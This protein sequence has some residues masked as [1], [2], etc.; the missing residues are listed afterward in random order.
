M[1]RDIKHQF[2]FSHSPEVVW[3]YLTD[4]ELLALWLMPSDF[5]LELD[6][7]FQFKTKPKIN[8]GF[9]GT[10]YCKVLEI[11]P[12]RKL[13]YSWQGGMS[14]EI[15]K[16]D[17]IVIWTLSPTEGGTALQLEHNGFKGFKNYL[18]YLIM[19]KGWLKIGK[20]LIAKINAGRHGRA[21]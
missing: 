20:R 8:L 9:D 21:L 14:K 10:V 15:P 13:V 17:S 3:E 2:F 5:K 6:H 18:P 4:P 1:Q 19:N 12:N 16:L 11:V 7:K